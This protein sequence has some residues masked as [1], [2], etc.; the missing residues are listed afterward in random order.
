MNGKESRIGTGHAR[1][2]IQ[3]GNNLQNWSAGSR[4]SESSRPHTMQRSDQA[5]QPEINTQRYERLPT[6]CS[7]QHLSP[8]RDKLEARFYTF[9]LQKTKFIVIKN[10]PTLSFCLIKINSLDV[11][12]TKKSCLLV[13][14]DL[15]TIIFQVACGCDKNF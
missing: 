1:R 6:D 3:E 13:C 4:V 15:N 9:S 10:Y 12:R 11:L 7:N 5:Q 2:K 14:L 8:S